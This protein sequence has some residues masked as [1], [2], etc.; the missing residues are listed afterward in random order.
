MRWGT[1]ALLAALVAAPACGG[2]GGGDSVGGG[3]G[4][5]PGPLSAT[6][7]ADMT[8]PTSGDVAMAQGSHSNDV[9]TVNVTLTDTNGV[10]GTAFDATYDASDAVYLGYSAG[11]ALEQGGNTPIY[12]VNGVVNGSSGRVVVGVVRMGATTTNISGTKTVIA[13]QFR[14]KNAGTFPMSLQNGSVYDNQAAPQPLSGISWYAG[15]LKG[16]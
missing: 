16:A 13:L 1:L 12:T 6:F 2:G 10:F 11:T 14:V 3:P 7:V 4:G 8:A 9:V 15:A 5:S